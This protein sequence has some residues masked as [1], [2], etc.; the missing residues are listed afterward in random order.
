MMDGTRWKLQV[1]QNLKL[2][3]PQQWELFYVFTQKSVY[4]GFSD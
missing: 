2:A 1:L 3:V 4:S